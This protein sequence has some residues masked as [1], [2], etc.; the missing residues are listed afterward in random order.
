[1]EGIIKTA[2]ITGASSGIGKATAEEFAKMGIRMI[3][4]ARRIDRIT[5]VDW[6]VEVLPLQLDVTNPGN[7]MEDLPPEWREIDIL[8]NNAGLSL[9]LDKLYEGNPVNW[10]VMIDT[11]IKGLLYMTRALLPGMIVRKRGDIINISS[12]SGYESYPGGNVYCATKHAVRAISHATRLDCLGMGV[13]VTDMAP[14]FV[15]TEFSEVRWSDKKRADEFYASV[16][17]LQAKDIAEAI[18]FCVTRPPHVDIAQ[19][20]IMPTVQAST[21]HVHKKCGAGVFD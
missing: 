11:N 9:T 17:A 8:V 12:I 15:E 6:G 14:G 16:E 10:D 4:I 21:V 2:L 19:M 18:A 20:L 3:L 1:M 13:R 5:S 7:F